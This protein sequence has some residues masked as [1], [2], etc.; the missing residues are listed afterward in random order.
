MYSKRTKL[1]KKLNNT[2]LKFKPFTRYLS[3]IGE[4]EKYYNSNI[5]VYN[6]TQVFERI[7]K[8]CK[9]KVVS[10]EK[11]ERHEKYTLDNTTCINY[12]VNVY[13]SSGGYNVFSRI[14]KLYRDTTYIK[15]SKWEKQ[16]DNVHDD[17]FLIRVK[18]QYE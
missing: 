15:E 16:F 1:L 9:D 11:L 17:F 3:I 14:T 18:K 6:K 5:T 8:M 7:R 2:K 12:K 10:I 13:R 4:L